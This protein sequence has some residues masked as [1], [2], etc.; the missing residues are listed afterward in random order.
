V[1][2]KIVLLLQL[3]STSGREPIPLPATLGSD[4]SI[5]VLKSVDIFET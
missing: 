5:S 4:G 1:K 3:L 2:E